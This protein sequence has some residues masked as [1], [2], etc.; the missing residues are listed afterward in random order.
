M[1]Y[2][3][4]IYD[5]DFFAREAY[6]A[7]VEDSSVEI[8]EPGSPD[9]STW[10]GNMMSAV[11]AKDL[12]CE[13]YQSTDPV[14]SLFQSGPILEQP[15]KLLIALILCEDAYRRFDRRRFFDLCRLLHGSD[16]AALELKATKLR[17]AWR[18]LE[19]LTKTTRIEGITPLQTIMNQALDFLA[20]IPK[21]PR[22]YTTSDI[23]VEKPVREDFLRCGVSLNN[24]DAVADF[25]K[26]SF[27]YILELTAANHQ[28]ETLFNY[29]VVLELLANSGV[30]EIFDYGAGIGTFLALAHAYG[31]SG[32]H[33]DL[34]SETM[35][36]ASARY[37]AMGI[38]VPLVTLNSQ[39][40]QLSKN[41]DCIACTEV[42]E[43]VF[44]PEGL[45]HKLHTSLRPNG[46]LVV[47]ES[48][49]Y[50]DE[51]CTHLTIHRGKGGMNF[52]NF[53]ESAGF[54]RIP[55]RFLLHPSVYLRTPTHPILQP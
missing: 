25:Y 12:F 21:T 18:S 3:E 20:Q 4:Q 19:Q 13:A 45:V 35:R 28:V 27:S 22:T 24:P 50:T 11:A 36:F 23:K 9:W 39:S 34:D 41:I 17:Y 7:S 33:A 54:R 46:I 10:R 6:T 52:L 42:L 15:D 53:M 55:T 14:T 40:H 37:C 26:T 29:A 32:T 51:F 43:H 2:Y 30:Q 47:S 1:N 16:S 48:F 44:D 38:D 49:D 31:I 5:V 8:R